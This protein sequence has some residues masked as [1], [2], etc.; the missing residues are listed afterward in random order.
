MKVG[1]G[2]GQGELAVDGFVHVLHF[3][4]KQAAFFV[5]KKLGIVRGGLE[6][7][8]HDLEEFVLL[9]QFGGGQTGP[10]PVKEFG[11]VFLRDHGSGVHQRLDDLVVQ[12]GLHGVEALVPAY[13]Q[14]H[15]AVEGGAFTRGNGRLAV[16]VRLFV[17]NGERRL[18]FPLKHD[19]EAQALLIQRGAQLEGHGGAF[20]TAG[21]FAVLPIKIVFVA[22]G[23]EKP[24]KEA[25]GDFHPMAVVVEILRDLLDDL[26]QF[27]RV[28]APFGI[29]QDMI[30][31]NFLTH[32]GQAGFVLAG[33]E[34]GHGQSARFRIKAE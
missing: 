31:R 3:Q 5:Q 6:Y 33:S 28:L 15:L 32:R 8:L 24:R 4:G 20:D 21:N 10:H 22:Y 12:A 16:F 23:P 17:Q 13:P 7:R 9:V 2:A 29:A 30:E 14:R 34:K 1:V 26:G 25:V 18:A 11:D 19:V 27:G